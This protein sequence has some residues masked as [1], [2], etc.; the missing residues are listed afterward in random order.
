MLTY[1]KFYQSYFRLNSEKT[2]F[3]QVN[4]FPNEKTIIYGEIGAAIDA[5]HEKKV[6]DN[7]AEVT[8]EEYNTV[9]A[10]VIAFLSAN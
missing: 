9:K 2:F 10:E 6:S 3:E 5:L 7:W 4:N 8:E 1:Y